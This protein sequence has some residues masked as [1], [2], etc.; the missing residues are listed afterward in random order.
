MPN[1]L[2]ATIEPEIYVVVLPLCFRG[3]L[4]LRLDCRVILGH[5]IDQ[6]S[7]LQSISQTVSTG[8]TSNL[9]H[10][11]IGASFSDVYNMGLRCPIFILS[12]QTGKN[13]GV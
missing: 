5:Q 9:F 4:T 12:P 13:S 6:N 11:L 3:V 1:H 10:V 7:D 8:F 2:K